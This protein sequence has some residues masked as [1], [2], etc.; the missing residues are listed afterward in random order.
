MRNTCMLLQ[1]WHCYI[2]IASIHS[3]TVVFC[4]CRRSFRG[5]A[6]ARRWDHHDQRR[7]CQLGSSR[8]SHR[9]CQV[10]TKGS[11]QSAVTVLTNLMLN[12]T[13]NHFNLQ[14]NEL[15]PINNAKD[16]FFSISVHIHHAW[17]HLF[18]SHKIHNCKL[19][20]I[21]TAFNSIHLSMMIAKRDSFRFCKADGVSAAD[22][23]CCLFS[24]CILMFF[25]SSFCRSCKES[26]MLTVVQPYPVSL[27]ALPT[28]R[29][30]Y[31]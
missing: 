27:F 5:K 12:N 4:V 14:E 21:S 29:A 15:C 1:S 13:Q 9:S 20:H 23:C 16:N 19:I 24:N 10:G 25:S 30:S 22:P 11:Y 2:A 26:I 18:I 17:S 3:A 8:A 28:N 6:V 7:T 31:L